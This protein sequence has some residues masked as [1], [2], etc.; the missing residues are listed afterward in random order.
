MLTVEIN[1]NTS[2]QRSHL[3]VVNLDSA[4]RTL[5]CTLSDRSSELW[6]D[7]V[8]GDLRWLLR[9]HRY[10]AHTVVGTCSC[11]WKILVL[12]SD[13]QPTCGAG[14]G[15]GLVGFRLLGHLVLGSNQYTSCACSPNVDRADLIWLCKEH[16]HIAANLAGG[17]R[18]IF[19]GTLLYVRNEALFM[20]VYS[21]FMEHRDF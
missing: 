15:V 8:F 11:R 3:F 20:N 12:H 10:L 14:V 17:E 9:H 13:F 5:C 6:S 18:F 2:Y 4:G 19:C 21:S 16:K 1:I 7:L